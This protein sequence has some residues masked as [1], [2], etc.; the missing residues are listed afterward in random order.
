MGVFDSRG[1]RLC[2]GLSKLALAIGLAAAGSTAA[3][4][5]DDSPDTQR[6][7]SAAAPDSNEAIIVTG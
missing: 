4:A 5:Q 7:S 1:T 2:G 6:Q 3:L